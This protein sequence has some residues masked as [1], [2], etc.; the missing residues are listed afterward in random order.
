ML[1]WRRS[2]IT[3]FLITVLYAVYAQS[4]PLYQPSREAVL[5]AYKEASLLDSLAKNAVLKGNI[6]AH[7]QPGNKS[8]WYRNVLADSSREYWQV[9]ARTGI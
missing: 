3:G 7:W 5:H 9:D 1:F 6:R 2:I 8:F 4:L